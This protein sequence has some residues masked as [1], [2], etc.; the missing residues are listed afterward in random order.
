MHNFIQDLRY[1]F[2]MLLKSPGLSAAAVLTL[3]LGIGAN[4][5]MFSLADAMWLRPLPVTDGNR[6]VRLYTSD[7]SHS[8]GEMR[9]QTSYADFQDLR[10]SAQTL[11][12]ATL[13]RRGALIEKNGETHLY[14]AN[15]VS[16]NYFSVLGVRAV[17]GHLPTEQEMK[18][19]DAASSVV[20]SYEYWKSEYG[21]DPATI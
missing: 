7:P 17:A 3:A 6:L 4:I 13:Q 16:D 19:P 8:R 18:S 11:D 1:G 14:R 9:G 12:L 15:Q 20:I 10:A 5:A 2:R 21:G